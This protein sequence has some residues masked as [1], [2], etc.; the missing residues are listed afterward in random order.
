MSFVDIENFELKPSSLENEVAILEK[1]L[2]IVEIE[3][4]CCN[5]TKFF[6]ATSGVTFIKFLFKCDNNSLYSFY[7]NLSE[8]SLL[9]VL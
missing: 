6:N 2:S 9:P 3:I 5:L 8:Y 1:K 4:L 7:N